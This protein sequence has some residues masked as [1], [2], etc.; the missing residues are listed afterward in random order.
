M[1][2]GH[3]LH[4]LAGELS[5]AFGGHTLTAASPQGRFA[6]GAA[7]ID[8]RRLSTAEAWGKHLLMGFD[9]LEESLHI[10]LGLYGG[11]AL[12]QGS[13][14]PI[15]GQVRLRLEDTGHTADLRGPT[16]CVLYRPDEVEALLARLGPDPLRGDADPA[17]ALERIGRSRAAIGTLLMNQDV[18]AGIGNVYRAE[19][20]FR[21]NIDPFL[22]GTAVDEDLWSI[23]WKDIVGLMNEGV[24]LGR[25]DTVRPE[26][27]PGAMGRAPR[28]DD[29]GGEVYVYR[30]AGLGCLVCGTEIRTEVIAGRNLFWCPG[31][32]QRR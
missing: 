20:L 19:L 17:A 29:H 3:T 18:I 26:H 6:A 30:R 15:V 8:G 9:G 11:L 21:H 5:E 4:R 1:P 22:P 13:G 31:C 16:S 27:E 7:L 23:L 14:H 2:E 12:L 32:Q 25:I 10:H 24:R 28:E